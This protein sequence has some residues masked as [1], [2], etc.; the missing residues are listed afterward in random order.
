MKKIL[1]H[2][3]SIINKGLSLEILWQTDDAVKCYDKVLKINPNN[4]DALKYK[5]SLLQ[6]QN[7]FEAASSYY[8]EILKN[9]P[10]NGNAFY[11]KARIKALELDHVESLRLLKKAI[12]INS[13]YQQTA[14][15]EPAFK[16][17]ITDAKI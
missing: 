16:K 13:D 5:A 10:K 15:D 1:S 7:K 14:K 8:D 6:S 2:I 12:E 17:I 11:N 9:D 4:I 3:D